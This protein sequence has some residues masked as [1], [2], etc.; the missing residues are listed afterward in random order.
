M[1]K[2]TVTT[3]S[4][5]YYTHSTLPLGV[6]YPFSTRIRRNCDYHS[7]NKTLLIWNWFT[8]VKPGSRYRAALVNPLTDKAAKYLRRQ[9]FYRYRLPRTFVSFSVLLKLF[10]DRDFSFLRNEKR[11]HTKSLTDAK[12]AVNRPCCLFQGFVLF[13]HHS[14][15]TETKSTPVPRRFIHVVYSLLL[16]MKY[17]FVFYVVVLFSMD[18]ILLISPELLL[19]IK[20]KTKCT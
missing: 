14:Q 1:Q 10:C 5:Q 13:F 11:E 20:S 16:F 3:T 9:V 12:L 17:I 7:G 8:G 6:F 18:K 2:K 15:Q 4:R 19:F